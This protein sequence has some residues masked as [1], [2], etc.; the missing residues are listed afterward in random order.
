MARYS[1]LSRINRDE[2]LINSEENKLSQSENLI[3]QFDENLCSQPRIRRSACSDLQSITI[4]E[5]RLINLNYRRSSL[6]S[7]HS[8]NISLNNNNLT[9]DNDYFKLC[10][11]RCKSFYKSFKIKKNNRDENNEKIN[12]KKLSKITY[13]YSLPDASTSTFQIKN[14]LKR[15]KTTKYNKIHFD[16]S[17]SLLTNSS[18][19]TKSTFRN[20]L[21]LVKSTSNNKSMNLTKF[22]HSSLT[23][24][25]NINDESLT[26]L[27]ETMFSIPLTIQW[28]FQ[29]SFIKFFLLR[30]YF[31]YL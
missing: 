19:T 8:K 18:S 14:I 15:N 13:R 23:T 3:F 4:P 31:L 6:F 5:E 12:I 11:Q 17:Q 16:L 2:K 7:D 29:V 27:N 20:F 30:N 22:H 25:T 1:P 24:L 10:R 21:C 9:S 28:H 26:D